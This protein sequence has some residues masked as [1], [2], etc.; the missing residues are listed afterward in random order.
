MAVPCVYISVTP[1]EW[2]VK[3]YNFTVTAVLAA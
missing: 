1:A 2:Q 3:E